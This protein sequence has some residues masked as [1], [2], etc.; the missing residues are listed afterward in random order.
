MSDVDPTR[1][2][3]L[4]SELPWLDA[5]SAFFCLKLLQKED[6]LS[7]STGPTSGGVI[8]AGVIYVHGD[9]NDGSALDASLRV[10]CISDTH[11]LHEQ[12]VSLPP[13]DVLIHSGGGSCHETQLDFHMSIC[14][15]IMRSC[16]PA[17]ALD[18]RL[19]C[20]CFDITITKNIAAYAPA[21][22]TNK[23]S[24]PEIIAFNKWSYTDF[25][26]LVKTYTAANELPLT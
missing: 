16:R 8:D 6:N 7:S 9:K 15:V 11:C 25:L 26:D 14:V 17:F 22:F 10:V 5:S 4:T 12:V 2:Q 24:K 23:G 21:D 19:A 18:H 1:L 20:L 13:G 3:V